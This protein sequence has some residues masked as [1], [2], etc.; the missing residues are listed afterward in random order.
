MLVQR[1]GSL[2]REIGFE[3]QIGARRFDLSGEMKDA[4]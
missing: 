4:A 1:Q 3:I 2:V